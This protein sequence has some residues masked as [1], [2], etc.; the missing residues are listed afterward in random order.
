MINDVLY[1]AYQLVCHTIL[2]SIDGLAYKSMRV[3]F[4]A[5]FG[6]LFCIQFVNVGFKRLH[7]LA[8]KCIVKETT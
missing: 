1:T 3:S 6:L 8:L 2:E 7:V 5:L 4:K